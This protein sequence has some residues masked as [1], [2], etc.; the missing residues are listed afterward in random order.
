M[1]HRNLRLAWSVAWGLVALLLV[2]LWVRSYWWET[3]LH[4]NR[5]TSGRVYVEGQC[6]EVFIG[7]SEQSDR[8][9]WID[10]GTGELKGGLR[11]FDYT[12]LGFYFGGDEMFQGL[13]IIVVP[14]WFLTCAFAAASAIPWIR[15]SK[16]FSLRTL[17]IATTLVAVVLGAVVWSARG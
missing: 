11:N 3:Y 14:F 16:R 4:V 1:K 6:G 8:P 13:F 15:W 7:I 10:Y 9:S 5:A 12:V 17:L 2:V